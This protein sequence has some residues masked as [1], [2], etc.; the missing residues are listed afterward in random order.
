MSLT[1]AKVLP[2][3]GDAERSILGII[4]IQNKK[5]FEIVDL[6]NPEDFYYKANEIIFR[7]MKA[8][9]NEN[10]PID[11]V[12][13]KN[14]IKESGKLKEVGG[15]PYVAKLAD[16]VTSTA[17]I[18][19][20]VKIV[21]EK[22]YKRKL[23]MFADG[24]LKESYKEKNKSD[25]IIGKAI[26]D[27]VAIKEIDKRVIKK[28]GEGSSHAVSKIKNLNSNVEKY[29]GLFTGLRSIDEIVYG[30]QKGEVIL[31]GG[32]P[33]K[34]KT[35][36]ATT[37]AKHLTVKKDKVVLFFS[38]EMAHELL[39]NR[40]ISSAAKV[41]T[42]VFKKGTSNIEHLDKIDK[43]SRL[44]EKANLLVDDNSYAID[45]LCA[46]AKKYQIVY[47]PDCIIIDYLQLVASSLKWGNENE[48]VT[49]KSAKVKKLAKSL[50]VPIIL[51]SQF[52]RG[53]EKRDRK[54][55][56]PR[57]SDLRGSGSIE[58]DID[59][60]MLLWSPNGEDESKEDQDPTSFNTK[61]YEDGFPVDIEVII[62]KNRQ[63]LTG[64]VNLT[65]KKA[66]TLFEEVEYY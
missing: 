14:V 15:I 7:T 35:A 46:M 12:T 60:A 10:R 43:A 36:L 32:R 44:I 57:L 33:G 13:L 17:N 64:K 59:V 23:I 6:I 31:I 55:R 34:G 40:M 29:G 39:Q 21:K 37:I 48:Q 52:S 27:I 22:S 53:L 8:M 38:L 3:D 5:L 9:M 1:D 66:Y 47:N 45:G 61:K 18:M 26:T 20:Y 11:F 65:F 4:I 16:D 42:N 28:I 63:G 41:N 58:Q 62:A 51:L 49:D 54:D 2:S 24:I 50:N 56:Q 25:K 30:F 19:F